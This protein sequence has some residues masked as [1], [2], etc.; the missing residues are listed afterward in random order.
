MDIVWK[1]GEM[2]HVLTLRE[3]WASLIAYGPKRVETR[4]WGS[5]YRGTLYI[6]AGAAKADWRDPRIQQLAAL[7]PGR[8]PAYGMVLCRCTLVDCVRMNEAFLAGLTDP[9]ERMCG[10][11]AP[12][13]FAWLLADV[14]PL[15]RPFPAKGRLGLWQID[16]AAE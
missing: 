8:E 14:A 6:H 4:S 10:E 9:V 16:S 2:M 12:G 13:R 1:E 7:L 5:R 15:S 11:Y 3:P